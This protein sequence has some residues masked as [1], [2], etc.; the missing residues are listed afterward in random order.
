MSN[1]ILTVGCLALL[2]WCYV[3]LKTLILGLKMSDFLVYVFLI[4]TIVWCYSE[5]IK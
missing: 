3:E 4:A 1:F 5:I 2:V